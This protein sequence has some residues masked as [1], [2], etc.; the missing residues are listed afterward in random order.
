MPTRS[1][2]HAAVEIAREHGGLI[3]CSSGGEGKGSSFWAVLTLPLVPDSDESREF[4]AHVQ[5]S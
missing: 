4:Q 3:G 2:L 5:H 1:A